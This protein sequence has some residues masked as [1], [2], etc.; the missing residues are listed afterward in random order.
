MIL[1]KGDFFEKYNREGQ[2]FEE[3][4][5]PVLVGDEIEGCL[6]FLSV[7]DQVL[8]QSRGQSSMAKVFF[9]FNPDLTINMLLKHVR[10]EDGSVSGEDWY[11][12]RGVK[13]IGRP[14]QTVMWVV[15]V[16]EQEQQGD[17]GV[18]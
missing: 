8:F 11:M 1:A 3:N 5:T 12:V 17:F 2:D 14:G 6:Q 9:A 4:L 13:T 16:E 18:G 10:R 15:L 7:R